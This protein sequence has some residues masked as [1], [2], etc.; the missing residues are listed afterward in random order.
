MSF[1]WVVEQ[2]KADVRSS[3]VGFEFCDH[4]FDK[5]FEF[6]NVG[7]TGRDHFR[8]NLLVHLTYSSVVM[9][10]RDRIAL[11]SVLKYWWSSSTEELRCS[12]ISE[13]TSKGV[14]S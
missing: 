9:P 1:R 8:A 13:T 6:Q 12:F 11:A 10:V 14:G 7:V 3:W 5:G 4:E 2:L